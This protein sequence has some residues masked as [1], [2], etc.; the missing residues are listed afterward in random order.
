MRYPS[1]VVINCRVEKV[2]QYAEKARKE[3]DT[4]ERKGRADVVGVCQ[5]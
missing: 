4:K 1:G 3:E 5:S 2:S